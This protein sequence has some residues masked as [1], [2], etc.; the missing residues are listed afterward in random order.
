MLE[1]ERV[2]GRVQE[3]RHNR[4]ELSLDAFGPCRIMRESTVFHGRSEVRL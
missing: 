4:I 2:G 1:T 3:F